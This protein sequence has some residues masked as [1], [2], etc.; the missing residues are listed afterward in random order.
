VSSG[1]NGYKTETLRLLKMEREEMEDER[2]REDE[3]QLVASEGPTETH[4]PFKN[5]PYN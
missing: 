2:Q 4:L 5:T 3:R 1:N